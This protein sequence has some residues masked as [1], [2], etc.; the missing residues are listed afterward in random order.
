[1]HF[2][3]EDLTETNYKW[4]MHEIDIFRGVP[5]RRIF[6]KSNGYQVLFIINAF[7]SSSLRFTIEDGKNI[8]QKIVNDL[9]PELKSEIS[10][11]NWLTKN[12]FSLY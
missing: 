7:G 10:V 5:S 6:D 3:K 11:L 1:M 9:P 12:I 2:Q 8:E 4:A